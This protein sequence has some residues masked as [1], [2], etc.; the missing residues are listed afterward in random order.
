[1]TILPTLTLKVLEDNSLVEDEN[2]APIAATTAEDNKANLDNALP[3]IRLNATVSSDND[4]PEEN[5]AVQLGLLNLLIDE[6]LKRLVRSRKKTVKA[7]YALRNMPIAS[8]RTFNVSILS[9][10]LD[11]VVPTTFKELQTL[12]EAKQ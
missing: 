8:L 6:T 11:I 3:E 7:R 10:E 9:N 1:M 12:L 2:F 5:E 4:R